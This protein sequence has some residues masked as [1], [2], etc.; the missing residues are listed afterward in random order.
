MD[1]I[2]NQDQS[3]LVDSFVMDLESTLDTK[4]NRLSFNAIWEAKPPAEACGQILQE[5]MRDV[6][7]YSTPPERYS[8]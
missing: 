4:H 5:Y 2:T 6:S 3:K 8:H 7:T 1:L